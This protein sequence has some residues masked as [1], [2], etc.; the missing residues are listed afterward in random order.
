M[1]ATS[2]R[3]VNLLS[4]RISLSDHIGTCCRDDL[5]KPVS[6]FVVQPPKAFDWN[7][8][9]VLWLRSHGL[10]EIQGGICPDRHPDHVGFA[11]QLLRGCLRVEVAQRLTISD[12]HDLRRSTNA[13]IH[14]ICVNHAQGNGG[15]R[16]TLW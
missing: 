10:D 7:D 2:T 1:D 13:P 8:M 15:E 14:L 12:D 9:V 5:V 11:L 3:A 6:L 16:G 4:H